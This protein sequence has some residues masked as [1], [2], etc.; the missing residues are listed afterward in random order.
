ME[1]NT[2][3]TVGVIIFST[4]KTKVLLVENLTKAEHLTKTFGIPAGR[5][6]IGQSLETNA[7]RELKEET[8]L[9]TKEA[10][11]VALPFEYEADITRKDG[12]TKHFHLKTFLCKNYS[13][14]LKEGAENRPVWVS[15][16]DLEKFNLL[17]NM[18]KVVLDALKYE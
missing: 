15:I 9:I 8:G 10:N 2:I 4:D 13:G 7:A 12:S 6:E 17:P 16:K 1:K 5:L 14:D 3:E 18:K 11:L